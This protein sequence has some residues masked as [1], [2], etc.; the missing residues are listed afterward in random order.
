M[1]GR[2]QLLDELPKWAFLSLFLGCMLPATS[3][4]APPPV[5]TVQPL[6]QT[7]LL[8]DS[9]TFSVAAT[10][11]TAL[12]YQWRK[13]GVDIVGATAST[14]TIPR[15]EYADQGVYS[16]KVTNAGGSRIS[17]NATLTVLGPPMITGQP[18]NQM[19]TQGQPAAFSVTASG[20]PP[21]I[22]QWQLNGTA[23]PGATSS[24]LVIPNVQA[25]AVGSYTAVV[26][27]LF[28]ATVSAPAL[29]SMEPVGFVIT[30]SNMD[31]SGSGSFRQALI[32][33]N[34]NPG[35]HSIV[36]SIPGDG[37]FVINVGPPLPAVTNVVTI[38]AT[39]QRGFTNRPVVEL[40]GRTST[41]DGLCITA[42]GCTIRGLAIHGFP[43][44][45]IV[46]AQGP[47]NV[48]QGN[49]I[50]TDSDGTTRRANELHGLMISNSA[51]NIIGGTDSLTR[52]VV[53]TSGRN[54]IHLEGPG[55]NHNQVM[56]N[57]VGLDWTG[58]VKMGV[59]GS[60][61][62]VSNAGWNAIGGTNAGAGNITA[63]CAYDGLA[64]AGGNA[65]F[66]LVQGN[67]IGTDITGIKGAGNSG[68]GIIIQEA[69][70][71]TVGGLTLAAA[72]VV[73]SSAGAGIAI[74][75]RAAQ[76][77]LVQGNFVG[78]DRSAAVSMPNGMGG[79][80][81]TNA[82]NNTIGGPLPGAG[83][84]IAFNRDGGVIVGHGQCA[85][86]ENSLFSNA[87]EAIHLSNG[88]NDGA[89]PPALT[90]AV[91]GNTTT[92]FR[93]SFT[94]FPATTFR[95]EFFASPASAGDAKTYLGA[96]NVTTDAAGV[97]KVDAVLNTGD[98]T[99]QYITATATDP[100]GRTSGLSV[101]VPVTAAANPLITS[102][103]QSLTMVAGQT[104]TLIVAAAGTP[105]LGYRWLCGGTPLP[106]AT[107][108]VLELQNVQPSHAGGYYAVVS[109]LWGAAT[110]TVATL[111]VIV[112][113]EITA[114]PQSQAVRVGESATFGIAASGT[115]PLR[116]QWNRDGVPLA[117]ATGNALVLTSAQ[118]TDAGNYTVVVTNVAGAA[119]SVAAMLTVTNPP[120]ITLSPGSA[121]MTSTG[122]VFQLSVPAGATYVILA[123]T[124]LGNWTPIATNVAQTDSVLFTDPAAIT[125]PSRMYRARVE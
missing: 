18:T 96:V 27:N 122:F 55:A 13:D 25:P 30:V 113:P 26:S 84:T 19:V 120:S 110:S 3:T 6:S 88:G 37:P 1:T 41:G 79:A 93:G 124:D 9:V 21:F 106:V 76:F 63:W 2:F 11:S 54:G 52:N 81:S 49:F 90:D 62:V 78:T 87:G 40:S 64:I 73:G 71:N 48:V 121:S 42:G 82:S 117:G 74:S 114:Q 22:Y 53:A 51:W 65:C 98:K 17:N 67:L 29:L 89:V 94:N 108:S 91:N 125:Y 47:S 116:Y 8:Y 43:G 50:G 15:V 59:K 72:N 35:P 109:N 102:E 69:P 57:V 14:F 10:S 105:P 85:I 99:G 12:S 16:V 75:G 86:S 46:L 97:S 38:D 44:C 83:N 66:N 68:N 107:N 119:T 112:P 123:S 77:N 28:G 24:T 20:A 60:G 103:P 95:I 4:A 58:L 7:V 34:T 111:T 32:N 61:I 100:A 39:T 70:S 56:G 80:F 101:A 45:A 31:D 104:A 5:I 92:W 23:L 115:G 33:A 118:L 36:F